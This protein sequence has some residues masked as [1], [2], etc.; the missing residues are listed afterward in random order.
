MH[1]PSCLDVKVLSILKGKI[2]IVSR[3]CPSLYYSLDVKS[4]YSLLDQWHKEFSKSFSFIHVLLMAPPMYL[5]H[6]VHE[7]VHDKYP[8]TSNYG[9][10]HVKHAIA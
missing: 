1:S 5:G 4:L 3:F 7:S 9:Q 2:I 6:Y 8:A 10:T